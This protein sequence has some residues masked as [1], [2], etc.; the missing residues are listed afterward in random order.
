MTTRTGRKPL[1]A[2]LMTAASLALAAVPAAA[3][4]GDP[5]V[6]VTVSVGDRPI[7]DGSVVAD[8]TPVTLGVAG[9]LSS[10]T[11]E[12]ELRASLDPGTVY[13]AGGV[14]APEGWAVQWSTD[15]GATWL[16]SEPTDPA[17]VTDVRATA[18]VDSGAI[19]RYSQVYSTE[20]VVPVPASSFSAST[21]GDGWDVSFFEGRVFNVF[22][23]NQT[24]VVLDCHVAT[25][26]ERCDGYHATFTGWSTADR[27]STWID[28]ATGRLYTPVRETATNRAGV[29]CVDV[30]AAGAPASCGFTALSDSTDVTGYHFL[31]HAEA[32]AGRLFMAETAGTEDTLLCFDVAAGD[33]C[34][35]TPIVLTGDV[36]DDA[37]HQPV[38]VGDRL[39]VATKDEI[40]CLDPTSLEACVG[41]WP[42]TMA[43]LGWNADPRPPAPHTDA[44]GTVD[45]FCVVAGCL[46]L[47]GTVTAWANTWESFGN[48]WPLSHAYFGGA[49]AG[50]KY[51]ALGAQPTTISCHD[52]TTGTTCAGFPVEV[53][54][55]A[56]GVYA[57]R[58]DPTNPSCLWW[59]SDGGQIGVVDA[60]TGALECTSNPVITLQPS[61]F[62]PRFSCTEGE[63]VDRWQELV[64]ESVSGT[65]TAGAIGLT[66]RDP[67]GSTVPGWDERPV[68]VGQPLDLAPL[69]VDETGSRPTF[70]FAFSD[71]TGG[72][73]DEAVIAITYAGRGPELCIRAE[74]DA[75]GEVCP[76][77]TGV[78]GTLTEDMQDGAVSAG[79]FS[80]ARELTISTDAEL[81]P[82]DIRHPGPPSPPRDVVVTEGP[83]GTAFVT[84]LHSEDDGGSPLREYQWSLDGGE[85]WVDAGALDDQG[86]LAFVL[87]GIEQGQ[88]YE[89]QMRATNGIGPSEAVVVPFLFEPEPAPV[90][91]PEPVIETEP[92]PIVEPEPTPESEP[93]VDPTPAA[94]EPVTPDPSATTAPAGD[95]QVAGALADTGADTVMWLW[96]S[97]GLVVAGGTG[98]LVARRTS[99][100]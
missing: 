40:L 1:L 5:G 18:P 44:D 20:T 32:V 98:V 51:F 28:P 57:L 3:S 33:R 27:S 69:P 85:T 74:L 37:S 60:N 23:H 55:A 45:G 54:G 4:A 19:D 96:L 43:D 65:G 91:E 86:L 12:R 76:V 95:Q 100:A 9:L 13:T 36:G 79:P 17:S 25:T 78:I 90:E 81:C 11:G 39:V 56:K 63:T 16:D 26:G 53:G 38:R 88:P 58:P 61:A 92:E 73:I 72:T 35:G 48:P 64:L 8:G 89:L 70:S 87:E 93:T 46:D 14:D 49:L 52:H 31:T 15:G 42:R 75:G 77:V 99:E 67:G 94:T 21:G 84:F 6:D 50:T 80:Q 66:V 82:E 22:H 83:D 24:S 29:F 2:A 59:N 97:L 10:G 68:T 30:A 62:A 7:R 41:T 47:T 34:A 71:V